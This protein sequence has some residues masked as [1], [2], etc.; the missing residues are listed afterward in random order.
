MGRMDYSETFF[1]WRWLFLGLMVILVGLPIPLWAL[2]VWIAHGRHTRPAG[3]VPLIHP[4]FR[5]G[6]ASWLAAG[7]IVLA[8]GSEFSLLPRAAHITRVE[9][10]PPALPPQ[11][12]G[13]RLA[14]LAD[15]HVG[16]LMSPE[17]A[18]RRLASFPHTRP[19]LVIEL[20]DITEMDPRY[21]PQAARIVGECK[22][23]LGT[24]AVAGNFDVQCGT[25]TL[26]QELAK[27]GVRY[28]ENRAAR[29]SARGADLWIVGVGD[30]WTGQ[31]DLDRALAAV[32]EGAT[33]ILLSH[34][35][36]IIER[37]VARQIP[38]MLSSHLHGGQV[39]VPFAGPAVGMSRY[40][41][42]FAWGHFH[43]GA[44][45]LVMS[46][47]LGEEALPLRL[48]CP[49]EIVLVTLRAAAE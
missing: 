15:H 44:T 42:R 39:V 16:P 31:D 27:A 25:D 33:A 19:D 12:D 9:V 20:G 10:T 35:P 34:S 8:A 2:A 41:T 17:R 23:P 5:A 13:L 1:Q 37:A 6:L 43:M 29:V 24:F 21:Q 3:S 28:L 7:A 11:L 4:V 14:V 45:H 38:L 32:P 48:F 26:R 47:G 49:P 30:P 40:G 18:R 22:A 46:R 36:D